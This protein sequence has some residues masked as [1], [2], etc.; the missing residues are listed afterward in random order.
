[1][2]ILIRSS[3]L[4]LRLRLITKSNLP[5][6][7]PVLFSDTEKSTKRDCRP[8]SLHGSPKVCGSGPS[9]AAGGSYMRKILV[10]GSLLLIIFAVLVEGVLPE[11]VS[12]TLERRI[13]DRLA[14]QDAQVS[15][16]SS[17]S[18]V[19]LL[20]QVDTLQA[21]THQAKVGQVYV[22]ELT[23]EGKDVHIDMASLLDDEKFKVSR[24]EKLTLQGIIDEENLREVLSR[25]VDKL[26]NVQVKITSE[27]VLV[28]AEV[29]V[30]GRMSQAELSGQVV[31]D[32]GSLYFRME[33]LS[34]KN[35][36]LGKVKLDGLF[37]DVFG[38]VLLAGPDK[39]PLGMRVTEVRQLEG[40]IAVKAEMPPAMD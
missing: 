17:P 22:K 20:G 3:G 33:H 24:A 7:A 5:G 31:D 23:L 2:G 4:S 25:R 14:S 40:S 36:R 16:N 32:A 34:L 13:G 27:R 6:A 26:E 10:V 39:I 1:M 37:G 19:M 18:I 21:V 15:I 8:G 29:K 35:S 30:M 38:D 11:V 28:T 9:W 12:S